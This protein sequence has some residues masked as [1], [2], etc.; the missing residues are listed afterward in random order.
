MLKKSVCA[1]WR[2]GPGLKPLGFV[3]CF[4]GL[5]PHANPKSNRRGF[6]AAPS[7]ALRCDRKARRLSLLQR[8]KAL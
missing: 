2:E 8:V 4:V 5:K 6:A 7:K 1:E 3:G